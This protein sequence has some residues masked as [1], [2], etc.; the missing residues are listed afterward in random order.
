MV[1]RYLL[2][3]A[4]NNPNKSDKPILK[5]FDEL[6][7]SLLLCVIYDSHFSMHLVTLSLSLSHTLWTPMNS[8]SICLI[9]DKIFLLYLLFLILG[10]VSLHLSYWT[11]QI[12][13]CICHR[14]ILEVSCI[15]NLP[16][17]ARFLCVRICKLWLRFD[18]SLLL[19]E[20]RY[21]LVI[22]AARCW[23]VLRL[24]KYLS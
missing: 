1:W 11:L 23:A 9:L 17:L 20:M 22:S 24:S 15:L 14:S 7:F 13:T 18:G 21:L 16:I 10:L 2:L 19:L 6:E 8:T 4:K 3:Y 5:G 12:V